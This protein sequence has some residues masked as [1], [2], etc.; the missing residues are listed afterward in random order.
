MEFRYKIAIKSHP[1]ASETP[2]ELAAPNNE[3]NEIVSVAQSAREATA[4]FCRRK[5]PPLNHGDEKTQI[6]DKDGS[7]RTGMLLQVSC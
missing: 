2:K 6:G 7:R 4:Y 3:R 1:R 5:K